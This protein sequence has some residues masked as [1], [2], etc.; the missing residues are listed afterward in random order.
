MLKT[1]PL[2]LRKIGGVVSEEIVKTTA[3]NSK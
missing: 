1:V 2:D 3:Y